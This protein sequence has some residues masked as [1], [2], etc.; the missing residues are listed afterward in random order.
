MAMK[1]EELQ[2]DILFN[3]MEDK[4][5][6]CW[7]DIPRNES[8]NDRLK[9]FLIKNFNVKWV[10][11]ANIE[12]NDNNMIIKLST[13]IIFKKS[14]FLAL[15]DEKTTAT[16]TINDVTDEFDIKM[17]EEKLK[18]FELEL[19][20]RFRDVYPHLKVVNQSRRL[21]NIVTYCVIF[22]LLL[23]FLLYNY[24]LVKNFSFI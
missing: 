2:R 21:Q 12:K 9:N 24:D 8:D 23:L 7:D 3:K 15:N 14:L 1:I 22:I 6:F 18:V 4:Y 16:L 13:G 17:D 19:K 5:L 20:Y 10:K 11:N